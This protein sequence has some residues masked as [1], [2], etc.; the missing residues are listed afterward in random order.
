MPRTKGKS[1]SLGGEREKNLVLPNNQPVKGLRLKIYPIET[2]QA[3][4]GSQA[5]MVTRTNDRQD[6]YPHLYF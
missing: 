4:L 1:S 3:P 5:A 6:E 2:K